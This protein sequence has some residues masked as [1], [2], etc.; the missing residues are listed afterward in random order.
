MAW[1]NGVSFFSKRYPP[2]FRISQSH[3][4]GLVIHGTR[5]WTDYKVSADI[6]IHLGNYGGVCARVQGLRRYYAVRATRDGKLQIVRTR[7]ADTVVL[8]ETAYDLVFEKKIPVTL[9]V[10]GSR[11]EALFGGV[12]IEADDATAEALSDGGIGLLIAEGALSTD[13]LHV[14]G[15]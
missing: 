8:A 15:A 5:Q 12:A 4:E 11:I 9:T 7:D 14:S 13:E 6:A 10:K 3:D 2:S 1:V